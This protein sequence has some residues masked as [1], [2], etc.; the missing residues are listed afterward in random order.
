MR[1]ALSSLSRRGQGGAVRLAADLKAALAA[2]TK[3]FT[4]VND[5]TEDGQE[6]DR[7]RDR[8]DEVRVEDD[9]AVDRRVADVLAVARAV[10]DQLNHGFGESVARRL[11][12]GGKA[13]GQLGPGTAGLALSA[14]L[15]CVRAVRLLALVH[16]LRRGGR[17][18]VQHDPDVVLGLVRRVVQIQGH[19][20]RFHHL[21][22]IRVA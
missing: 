5:G 17:A 15:A 9:E 22:I 4:G 14:E 18:H 3:V 12:S 1:H 16:V 11:E 21:I 8:E 19:V 2:L 6:E 7:S 10:G 20:R 13:S